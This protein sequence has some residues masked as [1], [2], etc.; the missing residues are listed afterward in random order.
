ME[1]ATR[2]PLTV[3]V[4]AN[5]GRWKAD[6]P[7]P[8][9]GNAEAFGLDMLGNPGGLTVSSFR[10]REEYGGCGLRCAALWPTNRRD[11]EWVLMQ[12][13]M[14]ST[15]NWIPGE[16]ILDL[17]Q[18][19]IA[20]GI[21]PISQAALDDPHHP[22]GVLLRVNGDQIEGGDLTI[23]TWRTEVGGRRDL[24]QGGQ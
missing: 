19:N 23:D 8:Y 14:P 6:C 11:I 24:E 15:R 16:Q 2:G 4:Y 10:C 20:H 9:C 12:R 1:V 3:T 21:Q 22:G 13:E 5:H 18:E 17:M 7:R